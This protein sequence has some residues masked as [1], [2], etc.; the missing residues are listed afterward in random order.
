[1]KTMTATINFMNAM[2][3]F[4][5]PRTRP[6]TL[7]VWLCSLLI[8][9]TVMPSLRAHN[10]DQL[11]TSIAFDKA[12]LD[13]MAVRAGANHPLIQAG[14]S[15][16]LILKSTP[17]PGTA[18]GAGGYMT[19]YIPP[20]TQVE[21][22]DYGR[23]NGTGGFVVI[24]MKGPSIMAVGDGS[25]GSA[26]TPG[27][28]G[29]TLGP[30][31]AG[32]TAAAVSAAGVHN[33]TLAG[34]YGDVGIFFSTDPETVW[35]SFL[36]AGGYDGNTGTA[37]NIL[38]NNRGEARVP[39]TKWDAEQLI[40]FGLSSPTAPIL[41]PNGRGNSPWGTASAVAGPQS[42]YQWA[43]DRDYYQAN[44][45]DPNRL[46]NSIVTG[47]WKRI[48][49]PG[50]TI[51]K[52]QVGLKST[53]LGF[54]VADAST[55]GTAVTPGSP[56]PPTYNWTDNTSPKA[57]RVSFGGLVLGQ[58][59]YARVQLKILA[60]PGQPNSPFDANG[61][62]LIHT[63]TFGGD[64]GG[65]QGGKDH[66]W[67]Y[68]DPTTQTVNPCAMLQKQFVKTPLAPGETSFFELAVINTGTTPMNNVVI[69]DPM[70][71]GLTYLSAVP[72]PSSTSPLTFKLGTVP[73]QGFVKIR[74]NFTAS[75]SGT[76]FNT[77]TMTSSAGTITAMDS[78][79]IGIRSILEPTKSVNPANVAPGATVTYSIAINNIGTGSNG[80]PLVVTDVLPPGFTYSGFVSAQLN[81]AAVPSGVITV[82]ATD[83]TK[84][85]YTISQG[86]Q[87]GKALVLNF[88][89]LVSPSQASGTY[90]NTVSMNYEGKVVTSGSLAPVTVGGGKIGDTVWRDWD[91][92]GTQDADEEGIPSLSVQLFDFAGTTLLKTTTTD[93]TGNYAFTGLVPGNYAVKIPTPPAG[94]TETYDLDGLGSANQTAITIA[95]DEEKMTADFGYRPGG[96]GSIGDTVFSDANGDGVMNGADTGIGSISVKLYEDSN[97]NGVIDPTD[98]QLATTITNGSGIY[99]FTGLAT[100]LSYLVDVDETDPDLVAAFTPN[101][102]T[103][104]TPVILSVVNLTGSNLTADFGYKANIPL[105]IGDTVFADANV[106]AFYDS[107]T[108]T[109]LG[110]IT[111]TLFRDSNADG[112]ADGPAIAT[113][114]TDAAGQYSFG[115]L[116]PDTY[117]VVVDTADPEVPS[118]YSSTVS[119]HNVML[120]FADVL[121]ADFPFVSVFSK[122]VD[123]SIAT[124]GDTLAYTMSPYWPGPSLLT[125]CSVRDTV[126][127][128]T[129]FVS[130]GQG[131]ALSGLTVSA[132]L[133]G[134]VAAVAA[135]SGSPVLTSVA[136]NEIWSDQPAANYG[137][138]DEMWIER[139]NSY[140]NRL[141]IR[142][143]L[144]PPTI[145]SNATISS[146]VMR[147]TKESGNNGNP[148]IA[149]HRLNVAWDETTSSWNNRLTGTPWS[150][151]GGEGDYHPTDEAT[152]SVTSNGNYNWTLTSL[153]QAWVNNSIANNGVIMRLPDE[154]TNGEH[155]FF[156]REHATAT[157]HPRLTVNWSVAAVTGTT[158]AITVTPSSVTDAGSGVNVNVSMTVTA[159]AA[160]SNITPTALS[161]IPGANGAT[162]TLVS[163]PT[164][165]PASIGA[166][167]G[168]A[169]FTWVY[170]VFK[171]TAEDQV[172]FS[173]N[174]TGT[175]ATF[176]SAT[177]NGVVVKDAA[178]TSTAV[179]NL[180]SNSAAVNGSQTGASA[181]THVASSST[182]VRG[183]TSLSPA[184]P[185]GT[186]QNDVMIASVAFQNGSG[187]TVTVPS[188]WNLIRRTNS[189]NSHGLA[190]YYKV[191]GSS[192]PSNYAFSILG[193]DRWS[194]GIS[195]FRNVSTS[196]PIDA[197]NGQANSSSATVTAPAVT[198]TVGETMLVGSFT[199]KEGA[200]GGST[201]SAYSNSMAEAYDI[202]TQ[203]GGGNEAGLGS[204]YAS[205]SS[206]GSTGTRT[207][208]AV[209]D[210]INIGHL[211]ALR[212]APTAS[213]TTA[214]SVLPALVT[215]AGSGV[216]VTV[217]QTVT[218]TGAVTGITPPPNLTVVGTNGASATKVSGPTGSG[219]NIGAGGGSATFTWVYKVTAGSTPGQVTFAGTPTGTG[220]IFGAATSHGIIVTPPLTMSVTVNT[221]A[222]VSVVDNVAGFLNGPTL[223][224]TDIALTSLTGSIGDYVWV[225]SDGDT[226]Q[227]S[228]EPGLAGIRVFVDQDND[229]VFDLGE[230]SDQTDSTG[231][232]R[233]FGL[234]AGSYPVMLDLSTVPAGYTPTSSSAHTAVLPTNTTRY[235]AADFGLRP[236]P[237]PPS[238]IGDT[239]W[240]DSNENG[241]VDSTESRLANITVNLYGDANNDGVIDSG[242]ALLGSRTTDASG[243]YLFSDLH[244]G[245]YLV[246]VI[247][248]DPDLPAGLE[249]VSGGANGAGLHDVTLGTG[250]NHTT[251]DFGYNFSGSIGDYL[252][253]DLNGD[254]IQNNSSGEIGVANAVVT[255][256]GDANNNGA[257]DAGEPILGFTTTNASGA[258]LFDNLPPGNYMVK[259][260]EQEVL[261]P[262]SSPFAGEP[263]RMQA[264]TGTKKAVAL[265][266]GQDCTT[267]DFGFLEVAKVEGYVFWDANGNGVRDPG[268][269]TYPNVTVTLIGTDANGA[270][271]SMTTTT[272]ASGEYKFLPPSGTYTV[273][274]TTTDPDLPAEL[275][276]RT[277]P[278]SFLFSIVSGNELEN[279]NFGV[280]NTGSIGDTIFANPNSN[281]TQDSGEPGLT[282]VV[283]NLYSDA[284]RTILIDSKV[285]DS[286][287]NY[288]FSGL[289]D[290][291]YY[292]KV[293]T[294]T[295]PSGY[296]STPTADPD[297]TADSLGTA[298][299]IGGSAVLT[300]DFGYTA[301]VPTFSVS[302]T[303]FD[304]LN[305]SSAPNV[306][307]EQLAGV[308]VTAVVTTGSDT[309]T[310]TTSTDGNG[311]YTFAVIPTG[312]DVTITVNPATLGS[313]AYVQTVDPDVTV[314]N[315]TSIINVTANVTGKNFGYVEQLGSIAGTVVKGDGDGFA[316]SGEAVQIGVTVTLIYAGLDGIEGTPDDQTFTMPTNGTGDYLF[317]DLPPGNYSISTTVPSGFTPLADRDGTNPNSIALSLTVGQN[318]VDQDF[319]Y[320][321][322]SISGYVW[323]DADGDGVQ[324][325]NELHLANVRVYVDV[326][327]DT[328]YDLGEP[329]DTTDASGLYLIS[330]LASGTLSVRVDT[331][332]LPPGS[333]PTYDLD[334]AVVTPH[335]ASVVLAPNQ[336]S[337][338]VDFGYQTTT[339]IVSGKVRLDSAGDDTL[340]G[341][342][343]GIPGVVVILLDSN[344]DPIA[345]TVTAPDGSYSFP[346]LVAGT[347][348]VVETDPLGATSDDDVTGSN[349][350]NTNDVVI[351]NA[352]V[353]G[354]D[355]LDEIE[356]QGYIYASA[357]G[358]FI[359]GGTIG[360]AG[361][362]G[363]V[364]ITQ[365]GFTGQ[366]GFTVD[367][368]GTYTMSYTPPAGWMIDPTRPSN[369][370]ILNPTGGPDPY[371]IGSGEN[372]ANPG[373]LLDYSAVANTYYYTFDLE[374]G[375]PLL[376]NN[377]IPLV[378]IK[379][380]NWVSWQYNNLLGGENGPSQN[381]DG[382]IYDNLQEF[383]FCMNPAS[384]VI[385]H[386][387]LTLEITQNGTINAKV[388]TTTGLTGVTVTLEYISDL[389][390]STANGGGWTPV[391]TIVPTFE[392]NIDGTTDWT[393]ADLETLPR[394]N[395]GNGFVRLKVDLANPAYTSRTEAAGWMDRLITATCDSY[396][397]SFLK[398]AVFS[399]VVDGNTTSSIN[400][401]TAIGSGNF[402][403][404]LTSGKTYNV[405][406]M[407]GP[408]AGHHWNITAGSAATSIATGT[409]SKSLTPD[410][411]VGARVIVREVATLADLFP[412]AIYLAGSTPTNSNR[413][414][415][416]DPTT[417]SKWTMYFL[418][419][420]SAGGLGIHWVLQG[421]NTLAN[422]DG[423]TLAPCQGIFFHHRAAPVAITQIGYVRQNP[424]ACPLLPGNNLI[425]GGYPVA[426]SPTDR[427]M[428][429]NGT[430]FNGFRGD[431]DAGLSDNILFWNGDSVLNGQNYTTSWLVD[432]GFDPYRRWTAQDDNSLGSQ[433]G[434][435]LFKPTRSAF[436]KTPT[437][438]PNYVLPTG[439]VP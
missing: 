244:A 393:F 145:P 387:P 193:G 406:V 1:M 40:G 27:L 129:T 256:Y 369:P 45:T 303:I 381:P 153:T 364:T 73:A 97:S 128:G 254:K 285:A 275:T 101:T 69:S 16:G 421:D 261:A 366:Y 386:C 362:P 2:C 311:L 34:V 358:E 179:W 185:A 175:G 435:K 283:V 102:Y 233:V 8:A 86:I 376:L 25:V 409:G 334:G 67:R 240:V 4:F 151:A 35:Q 360:M 412:P 269:T 407:T 350:D 288:L 64:A 172:W 298:T 52:D 192:E 87:A 70:P 213:T 255:L 420:L 61:C 196:T 54:A 401:A 203:D 392:N 297:G 403:G 121:T 150:A 286:S 296:S 268:E 257:L 302:G 372:P 267:A 71:A 204:A 158:T 300:Q 294:S 104:T 277:T 3:D 139:T 133:N 59:E 10:L 425:G 273:A 176:A 320:Q 315:T 304:D 216:D 170:K 374:V 140:R 438:N 280:D 80:T 242:D 118:G 23:P 206:S 135:S 339:Y 241:V 156:T 308:T 377:N 127:A 51:A 357:T 212:P 164:N 30:N 433:D 335:E 11:D 262:I 12:T 9:T 190:T 317:T 322:G 329:T 95:A 167:G 248:S 199:T 424:L 154:V 384:G 411:L 439:W 155:R 328:N 130:A 63:D 291:T 180:G 85:V 90:G 31:A 371:I 324:E 79:D 274:Y 168:S 148:D 83:G 43:F 404:L 94:Y 124:A 75:G 78:V 327:D 209:S 402:A 88:T 361:G 232:Y 356:P 321:A 136:D 141:L 115:G 414:L 201:L 5:R 125:N 200:V 149:A 36:N 49:F 247:E 316:E 132:A 117:L 264:S 309:Q 223:L 229:G 42:G 92:D 259:V 137:T 326:D 225:D 230:P 20:G 400:I 182:S 365:D 353:T 428:I 325:A 160:V 162:A 44:S 271:V 331:T 375:G 246:D 397:N 314:N 341:D 301:T 220:S 289:A 56:L 82:N 99:S 169:T 310:F 26:T 111:V 100:G 260:E 270:P 391:T 58:S 55:L 183:G 178:A 336:E 152:T 437:G 191:A 228:A 105:K 50:S 237:A 338:D 349:T 287:G 165:S 427:Q 272:N 396:N 342:E 389:A 235:S 282:N 231:T 263:A 312:S 60:A 47:P 173:G 189:T 431:V 434:V 383:A 161:V 28:V 17:G 205:F 29:L 367:A 32:V 120:I 81:G 222:S 38:T 19:F 177:S 352:D 399:G 214:M 211:V 48:Q 249:N 252:W 188:G 138:L 284:A 347:Y 76:I 398:C 159:T 218:A 119:A 62:F 426:Q 323:N 343:P 258:Y 436:Y 363:N 234:V 77:A 368:A 142:F 98:A 72:A 143:D 122:S 276:T 416:Y 184:L 46:K 253:Y 243:Q 413:I 345:S 379:P 410:A 15:I 395:M 131:G 171:G 22:A 423:N 290:G 113:T 305:T 65:E 226:V 340:D 245:N 106:N 7:I 306:P 210:G 13:M 103:A 187:V 333:T 116:A 307:G 194:I 238:S 197:E 251:A 109:P 295:L 355:F 354:Q 278:V 224:A 84:P 202:N 114:T 348:R 110:S 134:S 405:E 37:D 74:V 57:V 207:A 163:G 195:S 126:P 346:N 418:A 417:A 429:W 41:D 370:A 344:D 292:T 313:P 96:T 181:I 166:G 93:S 14:D 108:D 432:A 236:A 337:T 174:A 419:D 373:H 208:T 107:G 281:A 415:V 293:E 112:I 6:R 89:A 227:D 18:T 68:Y 146:A 380:S 266:A 24:P 21:K 388:I 390:L 330:G 215:D 91:N 144:S 250:V 422:R 198:T 123:K 385:P 265:A 147:L 239:L 394:L 430:D 359:P 39:I 378:K 279:L 53:A 221:P 408:W 318:K 219:A 217:T 351:T 382:D 319:E 186:S 33:G 332:T 299:V 66:L 157:N